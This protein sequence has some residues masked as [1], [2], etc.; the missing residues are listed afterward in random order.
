MK[1]LRKLL[2]EVQQLRS[3]FSSFR[4]EDHEKTCIYFRKKV[5]HNLNHIVSLIYSHFLL[6]LTSES[7]VLY[8]CLLSLSFSQA[9]NISSL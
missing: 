8:I 3:E 2:E 6:K 7:M 1:L 4:G 5:N 9:L